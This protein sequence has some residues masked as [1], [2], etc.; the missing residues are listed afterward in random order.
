MDCDSESALERHYHVKL[1]GQ[2]HDG[3]YYNA[4]AVFLRKFR[5]NRIHSTL[6]VVGQ[7]MLDGN[8]RS[9]IH[10]AIADG[11][12]IANHTFT[13]PA[14]LSRLPTKRL[15]EEI[16]RTDRIL[17]SHFGLRPFGFRAPN[18]D[19]SN[20]V[21]TVLNQENYLY[22]CSLLSSPFKPLLKFIK[23]ERSFRSGYLGRHH[24]LAAPKRPYI[25]RPDRYWRPD[26]LGQKGRVMELPVQTLPYF[27]FPCHFSYLLAMPEGIGKRAAGL[28]V[29]WHRKNDQPLCFIFHL[30][31]LVDNRYLMGTEARFYRG[32]K[33]RLDFL[34][35]FFSLIADNFQSITT[36]AYCRE[37]KE[38]GSFAKDRIASSGDA[39]S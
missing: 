24:L 18:F 12:E 38:A 16:V 36:G 37:V 3:V 13:H 31:D 39:G 26:C 28:L 4:L 23:G 21:L 33:S 35:R 8:K 11:H 6:F 9:F 27:R 15:E 1:P 7:D 22:D 25:P 10:R 17:E 34:D 19:L 30:A 29:D 2:K 14:N 32:V 20:R 5:E